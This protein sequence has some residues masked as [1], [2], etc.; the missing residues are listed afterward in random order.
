MELKILSKSVYGKP[1]YY[2]DNKLAQTL[3]D[4]L[5]QSTLTEDNLRHLVRNGFTV[6]E[7]QQS[8]FNMEI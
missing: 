5:G 2:P 4:L 8:T 6:T 3:T 7:R 1:T